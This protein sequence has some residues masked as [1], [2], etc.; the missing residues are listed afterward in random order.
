MLM[1]IGAFTFVTYLFITWY[2]FKV[3]IHSLDV[4]RDHNKKPAVILFSIILAGVE[5]ALL[6]TPGQ[7]WMIFLATAIGLVAYFF[8]KPAM[9]KQVKEEVQPKKEKK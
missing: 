8:M 2:A 3:R 9:D 7:T 5:I 4:K 1:Q 6:R